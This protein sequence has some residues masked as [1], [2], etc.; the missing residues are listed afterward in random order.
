[1]GC[2]R[3][4]I[5]ERVLFDHLIAA[6]VHGSGYERIAPPGCSDRTLRR[7]LR[8]W[9]E[10]GHGPAPLKICLAAY[11]RIVGLGLH[12]LAVDGCITKAPCG[13]EVVGRV[14]VIRPSSAV[15]RAWHGI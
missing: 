15:R 13:G 1:M 12:D 10:A 4:R 5:P 3:R 11:D 2:H 7:R 6:L 9:A 14:I 8:E